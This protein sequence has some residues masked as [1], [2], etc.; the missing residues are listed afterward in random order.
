VHAEQPAVRWSEGAADL[1]G[2]IELRRLVFC[3]EQGVPEQ[4]EL[5]GRDGEALHLVALEPGTADVIGTLRLLFDG[6]TA[7]VGRV[8]VERS[9]RGRGLASRMLEEALTVARGHSATRARLASQL[10]VVPL[11][12]RAGFEVESGVFEDA[13][14]PH[15]WMSRPLG[16]G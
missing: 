6:D 2:A 7:K 14:I 10:E 11:Y 12:E 8:A 9:W 1:E 13:G 5:D 16:E 15:V 3:G 4:E